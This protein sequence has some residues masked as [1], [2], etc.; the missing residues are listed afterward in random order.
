MERQIFYY[1]PISLTASLFCFFFSLGFAQ[2]KL[3]MRSQSEVESSFQ[4]GVNFF[5]AGRFDDAIAVFEGLLKG[6]YRHQRLTAVLYMRARCAYQLGRYETAAKTIEELERLVPQSAYVDDGHVLL[7]MI[8]FE[9]A[10]YLEAADELLMVIESADSPALRSQAAEWATILLNEYLPVADLR[11]LHKA[12][13]KSPLVVM[14]LARK[15]IKQGNREAGEKLIDEFLRANASTPYRNELERLKAVGAEAP[16]VARRIGIILPLTGFNAEAG[17]GVYRGIKYAQMAGGTNGRSDESRGAVPIELVIRDSE[18]SIVG[19]LKV[20]QELLSDPAAVAVIGEIESPIS[21]AIAALAEQRGIPCLIPVATENGIGGLGEYV[22][23]LNADRE[24]K[25]RALAEYAYNFLN[26]RSF[27][28]IAP[29]DDYGQQMT[30]G[31]SAAIDSLGG[32]ILAQKW[33]YGEPQDLSRHF[34][35]LREMAFRK[36]FKD[37]IEQRPSE[38]SLAE[39]RDEVKIPVTNINAMFFPLYT[40]DIKLVASQWA[41]FNFQSIILGGENW[42]TIDWE[43]SKELQRY[44]EG[45]IF[46]SDYYIDLENPQYKQFR[47]DF[48]TRMGVTPEKWEILGYDTAALLL[49]AI[50]GGASSRYQ[51]K[52]ALEKVDGYVG[53]KGRISLYNTE[54]V[55]SKVNILQIR[56]AKVVKVY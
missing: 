33:Y 4:K 45:A 15:E 3:A 51:I 16:I 49:Q 46:A 23:Q 9:K 1:R 56:G 50:N 35:T 29:Q 38:Y 26:A 52:Q 19:A 44:A 47:N 54:H 20:A 27:V 2:E 6:D 30:D 25:S 41:Y 18:S 55:N 8:A 36:A 53:M 40:E 13:G 17:L 22:F 37:S 28:T 12:Y 5:N 32:E 21:A 11:H 14:A 48:R 43:K 42:Y 24:R 10:D 31:F 39:I 7:G 34:R